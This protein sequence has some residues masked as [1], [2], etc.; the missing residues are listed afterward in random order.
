MDDQSRRVAEEI[1]TAAVEEMD[2]DLP[3]TWESL[4]LKHLCLADS[5]SDLFVDNTARSLR[6]L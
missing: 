3:N 4:A 6:V 5:F 2:D 1:L